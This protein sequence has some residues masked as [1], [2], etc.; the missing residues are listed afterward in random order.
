M[1]FRFALL[2]AWIVVNSTACTGLKHKSLETQAA[3][4]GDDSKRCVV[5]PA[6]SSPRS[7]RHSS[8]LFSTD[9][10][11]DS[12]LVLHPEVESISQPVQSRIQTARENG[13]PIAGRENRDLIEEAAGLAK[14]ELVVAAVAGSDKI[15]TC[16]DQN[17]TVTGNGG[18]VMIS[19]RSV[20]LTIHG[21]NT[22]VYCDIAQDVQ[23]LGNG[24]KI[25]LGA[26]GTGTILGSGNKLSWEKGI[27]GKPPVVKAQGSNNEAKIAVPVKSTIRE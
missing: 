15:V 10:S 19:G 22:E 18:L 11:T 1:E 9:E 23:I 14:G 27:A 2:V 16:D 3:F 12:S 6:T 8:S 4:G 20:R 24:N 13:A 5:S 26:L 25:N 21:Q 7:E 17:V